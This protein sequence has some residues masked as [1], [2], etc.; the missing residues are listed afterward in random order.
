MFVLVAAMLVTGHWSLVSAQVKIGGSIDDSITPGAVLELD[1]ANGALLLPR[2]SKLPTDPVAGMQVYL[3]AADGDYLA[4]KVY[5][6][7]GT[8]WV[9]DGLKGDKGDAGAMGATGP[10]GPIGP[11]GA[12]GPAGAIGATGPAGPAGATGAKGATGSVGATG[13]AGPAG[14]TGARG[15]TGATGDRGATGA[16]GDRG[17]TG[18]TGPAGPAGATGAKGATGAT[19][20]AGPTGPKGATGA[21]GPAGPVGK[22]ASGLTS[23]NVTIPTLKPQ[24]AGSVSWSVPSGSAF[25]DCWVNNIVG[26]NWAIVIDIRSAS[27]IWAYN[28]STTVSASGQTVVHCIKWIN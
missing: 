26:S 13:P 6:Y 11:I 17:A 12:T 25:N 28:T 19:G 24:T 9:A 23:F 7:D 20:P 14:A 5:Y 18:A 4:N 3:T 21:T 22:Y 1:G 8:K 15:A 16:T 2:V 10:A 27:T